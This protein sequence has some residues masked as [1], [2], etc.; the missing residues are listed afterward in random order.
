MKVMKR[1][2]TVE[3]FKDKKRRKRQ[4]R[5]RLVAS[6][7]RLL[8]AASE[9]FLRR[10]DSIANLE[11]VTGLVWIGNRECNKARVRMRN[12]VHSFIELL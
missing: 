10:G 1:A 3:L 9:G 6:N 4:W 7:G 11:L 12:R 8:G 5:W 2:A